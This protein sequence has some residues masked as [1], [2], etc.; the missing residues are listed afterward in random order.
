MSMK[1]SKSFTIYYLKARVLIHKMIESLKNDAKIE[2]DH[3]RKSRGLQ[4]LPLFSSEKD[5]LTES[6]TSLLMLNVHN[7]HASIDI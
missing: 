5:G 4:Y 2:V 6:I 3:H 7:T 1:K